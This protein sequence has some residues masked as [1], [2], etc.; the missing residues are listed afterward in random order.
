[1]MQKL[2]TSSILALFLFISLGAF[3]QQA[4]KLGHIDSNEL[5]QLMPEREAA[6]AELE[7]YAGELE[8]QFVSMQGEFQT[9]YQEYLEKESTFSEL[10][11]Q[12]RQR[13]L[14]SLQ[15]R[16]MEFQESA[17]QDL[18]NQESQLLSPI[19]EKARQAIEE[20]AREEGFTYIFDVGMGVLL[21]HEKG[22]DIMPQVRAKL[23]I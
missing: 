3:A 14:A 21:F 9:K 12:S 23:G 13:E 10:I 16:I 7:R 22:E 5:L 11:R 6:M 2:L 19:I 8:E 1:M 17:Q 4:V 20:V 15:E 18:M